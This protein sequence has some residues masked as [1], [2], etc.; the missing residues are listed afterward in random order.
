MLTVKI[1]PALW[2]GLFTVYRHYLSYSWTG[3]FL[4]SFVVAY[5]PTYIESSHVVARDGA[6]SKWFQQ[7]KLWDFIRWY[8]KATIT[9]EEELDHKKQYI[10]C[11]FP[12]G[13]IS[14]NHLLT[15]TNGC[16]M[17]TKHYQGVRRDLCASV[18]FTIPI[19]KDVRDSQGH[20]LLPI[21]F[22]IL[23]SSNIVNRF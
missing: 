5:L 11:C 10:F 22:I 3:S 1:F 18:L 21:C 16:E 7:L 13:P 15:M 17:L 23:L 12:H 2:T 20:Q 8:F 19:F 9:L 14:V 4:L 6:A